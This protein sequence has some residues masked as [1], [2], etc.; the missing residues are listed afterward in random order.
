MITQW[1]FDYKIENSVL[2]LDG[3]DEIADINSFHRKLDSYVRKHPDQKIVISTRNNFYHLSRGKGQEGSL[4]QF[5]EYAIFPILREDIS[6]YLRK[7]EVDE[8]VFWKQFQ[9]RKLT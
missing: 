3:Y 7:S 8:T 4:N 2:V 9:M 6:E 5:K 1:K